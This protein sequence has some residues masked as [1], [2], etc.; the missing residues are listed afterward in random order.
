MAGD[1]CSTGRAQHAAGTAAAGNTVRA[2]EEK[3]HVEKKP[4]Q[5]GEAVI[6]KEVHTEHKTVEV[7]VTREELV[8]ERRSGSGQVSSADIKEGQEIRVPIKEEQVKVEKQTVVAEEV[9]V[10]KRKVKDTEHVAADLRKEEIKVE[11]KGDVNVRDK[12]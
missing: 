1:A 12:R 9:S 5:A 6:R 3:L 2:H 10:G 11:T 4:V 7:P 8:V